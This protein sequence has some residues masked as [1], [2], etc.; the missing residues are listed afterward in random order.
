MFELKL[1]SIV[2]DKLY[3]LVKSDGTDVFNQ[4]FD[5]W[6]DPQYLYDFFNEHNEVLRYYGMS[7]K[8]ATKQALT[9]SKQFYLK[10]LNIAEGKTDV[11][12]LDYDIFQPLHPRDDFDLPLISAKAYGPRKPTSFLRLYA[13][14]ISDGTYIIIG[15]LIKT[16][17][18]LQETEEGE[19]MLKELR[20]LGEYLRKKGFQDAFDLGVL[21]V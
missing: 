1:A 3:T 21:I 14:R 11:T 19:E 13:I 16:T 8:E 17:Q 2:E 5:N 7:A 12:T 15:G 18:E 6:Q 20:T 10:I 9:E 4:C